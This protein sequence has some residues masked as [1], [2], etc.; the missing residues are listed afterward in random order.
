MSKKLKKIFA[1]ITFEKIINVFSLIVAIIALF[2]SKT[3]LNISEQ[4]LR[5]ATTD[6]A[7]IPE[8]QVTENEFR[9]LNSDNKNFE[10]SSIKINEYERW[11]IKKNDKYLPY[12]LL[13]TLFYKNFNVNGDEKIIVDLQHPIQHDN[14]I[15]VDDTE[16]FNNK[17]KKSMAQLK[18]KENITYEDKFFEV[19][20]RY[21][22]KYSHKE[23]NLEL[24]VFVDEKNKV[25]EI[26]HGLESEHYET[27]A[28]AKKFKQYNEV[29]QL[30]IN[31]IDEEKGEMVFVE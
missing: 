12:V 23:E 3:S 21:I 2:I 31:Y 27:F 29:W 9:V 19:S 11:L 4:T 30:L 14:I 10:I 15:N 18:E 6:Y 13:N 8:I 24:T 26:V 25:T 20:I 22:H 17:F 5:Y 7:M 1:L 28:F 16:N